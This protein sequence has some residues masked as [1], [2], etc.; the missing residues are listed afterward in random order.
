MR[1]KPKKKCVRQHIFFTFFSF[2]VFIIEF[3]LIKQLSN[4]ISFL[5]KRRKESH[6]YYYGSSI[7]IRARMYVVW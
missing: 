6:W 4:I 1:F 2:W 7:Y 3:A 5:I